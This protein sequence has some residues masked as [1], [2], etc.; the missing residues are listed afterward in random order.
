MIDNCPLI[1]I[2]VPAYNVEKYIKESIFSLISQTYD[3]IEILICD[4]GSTD[5]SKENILSIQDARIRFFENQENK[6]VVYTRN[7][8]LR[9]AKGA[10]IMLQDADD[11][12]HPERIEK[13]LNFLLQNPQCKACGTQ[14]IKCYKNKII[15]K[16]SLP[17]NYSDIKNAIPEQYH[18]LPGTLFFKTT[19]LDEVGYYN[20]FF[21]NDGNEDLYWISKMILKYPYQNLKE[22]LYYYELNIASLTKFQISNIRKYYIHSVT[23]DLLNSYKSRGTNALE[24]NNLIELERLERE[25]KNKYIDLTPDDILEKQLGQ[26]IYFKLYTRTIITIWSGYAKSLSFWKKVKITLFILRKLVFHHFS[27]ETNKN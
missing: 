14:F 3:N 12:S 20:P 11:R 26:L 21:G 10:Y 18:F 19:L 23:A 1:S 15:N 8:L 2:I 4:D 5:R 25:V 16:S 6:G 17:S 13:Q 27:N 9:E 7:L 24:E 22:Y